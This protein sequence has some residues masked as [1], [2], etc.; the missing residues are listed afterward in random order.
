[1]NGQRETVI[2]PRLKHIILLSHQFNDSQPKSIIGIQ[3]I[4]T[5]KS[6]NKTESGLL[7]KMALSKEN[8]I[9]EEYK[10]LR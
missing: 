10:K 3:L 1:M 7:L 2:P 4:K 5:E 8:N 9:K 6:G